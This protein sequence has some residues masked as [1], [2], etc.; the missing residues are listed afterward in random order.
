[1]NRVPPLRTVK[2]DMDCIRGVQRTSAV[3]L[4]RGS[5][6]LAGEGSQLTRLGSHRVS[7]IGKRFRNQE[8]IGHC[9]LRVELPFYLYRF[10]SF[11][12]QASPL[13]M[14]IAEHHN[15]G[16]CARFL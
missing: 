14:A 6:H 3:D 9:I 8:D 1:M 13:V 7:I 11:G 15:L 2:L 10:V 4:A 12:A 16:F 5:A